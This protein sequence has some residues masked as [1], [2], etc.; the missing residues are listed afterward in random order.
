MVLERA[1]VLQAYYDQEVFHHSVSSVELT[2]VGTLMYVSLNLVSPAVHVLKSMYGPKIVLAAGTAVL[3]L[4]LI[5]AAFST[6]IWHLYLTQGIMYGIGGSLMYTTAMGIAPQ[7]FDKRRG[8][9]LGV[10]TSGSGIGGLIMPFI[11]SPLLETLGA[12]W[13]YRILG[14]IAL[15]V[16]LF[17]SI[18]IEER[19]PHQQRKKFSELMN[20]AILKEPNFAIWNIACDLCL[21]GYLVP[22][23]L[24]PT[25]AQDYGLSASQ[26]ANL[27]SVL[28]A[29]NFIGRVLSGFYADY[30]GRLNAD[31]LCMTVSGL[32]CG[33]LW[34][35]ATNYGI[36]IAFCVIYGLF[37]GAY[38]ALLAPVTAL[39]TG[40]ER[41]PGGFSLFLVLNA[42][43]FFGA[44][45]AGA[46]QTASNST[47][48]LA[49]Q[50]F[51]TVTFLLG[52][53]LMF[54][55]K[56]KMTKSVFSKI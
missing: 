7:W 4:S 55:L 29:F 14:F 19:Y 15:A 24:M 37:C 11:M 9:A 13:C 8:L 39:I 2:F 44:P 47:G 45:I 52:A 20:F 12:P 49:T 33:L 35:F 6:Q 43:G 26:G 51:T 3:S 22:F 41:F 25:Y 38:F 17:A 40:I 48:Y 23:Y 16:G 28:S 50:L 30:I 42:V 56:I 21:L 32:A 10:A 53:L 54:G 31:I 1:G 36:L 34:V 18:F 5:L 27:V 46:V